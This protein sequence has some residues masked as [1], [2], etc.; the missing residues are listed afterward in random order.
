MKFKLITAPN[1]ERT[2]TT[3]TTRLRH[4][5]HNMAILELQEFS[6]HHILIME[7]IPCMAK[8]T[9]Q[10]KGSESRSSDGCDYASRQLHICLDIQIHDTYS[11]QTEINLTWDQVCV[12]MHWKERQG[13]VQINILQTYLSL[14]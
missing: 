2:N 9:H 14:I 8:S 4:Q 1:I 7:G 11:H 13:E 6:T 3:T 10:M 12:H 5:M